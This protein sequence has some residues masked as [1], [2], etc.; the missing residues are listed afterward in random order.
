MRELGEDAEPL[1]RS[2]GRLAGELPLDLIVG[3]GPLGRTFA[4]A[5]GPGSNA[6]AADDPDE[7]AA[8]LEPILRPDDLVLFKASRAV[9]LDAALRR[10][11]ARTGAGAPGGGTAPGGG[12]A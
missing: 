2:C 11:E 5:A 8:M 1:H 7:A 4:E 3:V 10:L 9:G 6:L 12:D